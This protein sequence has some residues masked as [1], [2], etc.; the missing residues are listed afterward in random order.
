MHTL[1]ESVVLEVIYLMFPSDHVRVY[2]LPFPSPSHL[3]HLSPL[4]VQVAIH[5]MRG[6]DLGA[7]AQHG[8]WV[9]LPVN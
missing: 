3:I 9:R 5:M 7:H 8:I 2:F 1:V 6:E 4:W